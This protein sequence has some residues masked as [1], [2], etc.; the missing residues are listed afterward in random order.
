MFVYKHTNIHKHTHKHTYK[1]T[2]WTIYFVS[3]SRNFKRVTY[4]TLH[5]ITLHIK[6]INY[7]V[8][9]GVHRE[10]THYAFINT[11]AHATSSQTKTHTTHIHIQA[12]E[13]TYTHLKCT[14][15]N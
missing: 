3:S 15:M 4:V 10:H 7:R 14:E 12:H 9:R 6:Y 11:H 5:D 2:N 1:H 13:N 8:Q